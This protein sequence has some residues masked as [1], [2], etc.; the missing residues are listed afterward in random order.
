ME[1]TLKQRRAFFFSRKNLQRKW[2][3]AIIT[4]FMLRACDAVGLSEMIERR[5]SQIIIKFC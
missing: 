4:V 3:L 1:F 5:N 2:R